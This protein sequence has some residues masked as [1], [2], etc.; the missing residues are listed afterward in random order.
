[1]GRIKLVLE[2]TDHQP[3]RPYL[4]PAVK[5]PVN[6]WHPSV[7]H[8]IPSP[9]LAS[10][11]ISRQIHGIRDL[12]LL[13][14]SGAVQK[15]CMLFGPTG[16]GKTTCVRAYASEFQI[17][18]VIIDCNGGIDP[19]SFWGMLTMSEQTGKVEWVDSDVTNV[20]R[21]GGILMF[22]E[23]NFMHPKVAAAF[24]GLLDSRRQVSI[25][26][27]GNL[28]VRASDKMQAICAYNPD[29][30]GTRPLNAAFK[31]RFAIK[32]PWGYDEQVEDKLIYMPVLL[33]VAKKLRAQSE[34]GEIQTPV[35]TNMLIEFEELGVEFGLDFAVGNFVA[36]FSADEQ[37]AVT[38]AFKMYRPSL[39][40]QLREL[41]EDDSDMADDTDNSNS[42]EA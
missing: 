8:L 39:E 22:E 37:S 12:N 36:A 40:A 25:L 9:D 28:V 10:Q 33:T 16:P 14:Y 42:Q 2:A 24:H 41:E 31:N 38:E 32:L 1:M 19:N 26:E 27:R 11:Y 7:R 15:H 29:Y 35:S 6:P 34:S 23:V 30:E 3:E 20:I 5:R 4:V 18:L 17:P 13:R 21:H